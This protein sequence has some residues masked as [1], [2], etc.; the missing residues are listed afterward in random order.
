MSRKWWIWCGLAVAAVA[1]ALASMWLFQ[2]SDEELIRQALDESVAAGRE[3]RPGG[4]L[5]Y[6]S[7]SFQINTQEPVRRSDIARVV[8]LNRPKVTLGPWQPRIAG[9]LA[10]V[11]TSADVELGGLDGGGGGAFD[12]L[13]L[14][15][16]QFRLDSVT[17][18][19][20]RETD[21]RWLVVPVKKWRVISV[22][23]PGFDPYS[24]A[25]Q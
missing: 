4:V 19:L 11:E 3:G 10:V 8:R 6:L 23:A 9:D 14:P 15:K 5:E 21:R 13:K 20:R 12:A 17:I 22:S 25:G 2:P 7:Q 24:L 1:A 16:T 18:R